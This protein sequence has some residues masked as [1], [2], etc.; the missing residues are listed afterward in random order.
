MAYRQL[1][2]F[3]HALDDLDLAVKIKPG[4][5]KGYFGRAVVY[6]SMKE[7]SKSQEDLLKAQSLGFNSR[8]GFIEQ[9]KKH[10]DEKK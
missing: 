9:L 10:L 3:Q 2:M 5:A 1:G 4:Y 7:Y 6:F 8:A